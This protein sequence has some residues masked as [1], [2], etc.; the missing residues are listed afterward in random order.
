M[1]WKTNSSLQYESESVETTQWWFFV[2]FSR[3]RERLINIA[4]SHSIT[5]IWW[6]TSSGHRRKWK[7]GD[8]TIVDFCLFLSF[9]AY[10][11]VRPSPF[12]DVFSSFLTWNIWY[13]KHIISG[14]EFWWNSFFLVRHSDSW[15]LRYVTHRSDWLKTSSSSSEVFRVCYIVGCADVRRRTVQT[16][17]RQPEITWVM[18][19]TQTPIRLA[20]LASKTLRVPL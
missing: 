9:K 5:V 16:F 7:C 15:K 4:L 10:P 19:K 12:F 14:I 17:G 20:R 18:S 13:Y 3:S 2:S 1:W 8:K 11:R 6:K